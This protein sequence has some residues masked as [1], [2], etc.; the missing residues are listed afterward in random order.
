MVDR[1]QSKPRARVKS[2]GEGSTAN[3]N[4]SRRMRPFWELRLYVA[5]MTPTAVRALEN[6][7][8]LCE[9]HLQGTYRIQ[10]VDLLHRPKLASGDQIVAVPTL[11]RRL[12]TP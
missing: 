5:G 7:K 2:L 12:P 4:G 9:K 6:L 11:V 10:V 1:R 3:Q 8:G